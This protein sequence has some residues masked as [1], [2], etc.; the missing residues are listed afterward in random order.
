[1]K[2]YEKTIDEYLTVNGKQPVIT[3]KQEWGG[4]ELDDLRRGKVANLASSTSWGK[5]DFKGRDLTRETAPKGIS[6]RD[7]DGVWVAVNTFLKAPVGTFHWRIPICIQPNE[8]IGSHLL[9]HFMPEVISHSYTEDGLRC[10][11]A[12]HA[13]L[14]TWA[15]IDG[16]TIPQKVLNEYCV[17]ERRLQLRRNVP[18]QVDCLFSAERVV[19]IY[20]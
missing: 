15:I 2:P 11:K 20:R 7:Y 12:A 5:D 17:Y 4:A 10:R 6:F 3:E 16:E 19:E 8:G 1:M 13:L 18:P 9:A 14:V